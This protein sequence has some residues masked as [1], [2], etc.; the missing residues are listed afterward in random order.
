MNLP[1]YFEN[2]EQ[3]HVG[4][5]DNRSYYIPFASA[6]EALL[7]DRQMSDRFLSLNGLWGFKY[8]D[9]VYDL[10][11]DLQDYYVASDEIPVPSVWQNYG[12]DRHQYTNLKYPIPYDPPYVPSENPTGVYQRSFEL[13]PLGT[14][15]YYLNF[16]GVDSCFYVWVNGQFVGY[17]QV[18]HSTSEFEITKHLC[19]GDNDITVAVLKWCDGTYLEDQDKLRMSGIFR[20]V[21]L[22]I[23]P[24]K[25]IRDFFCHVDLNKAYADATLDVEL[26]YQKAGRTPKEVAVLAT[27]IDPEGEVVAQKPVEKGEVHFDVKKVEKW[28]AESPKLYSLLLECEEEVICQKIGFRKVEIKDGVLLINGQ[29]IK[30][31]GVN[32]HDSDPFTGYV[33]SEEQAMT[34]LV[35]MKEHNINAIRT[36]H[37]PNAPWFPELCNEFGFYMIAESDL[38]SHGSIELAGPESWIDKYCLPPHDPQFE[39]ATLDRQMLSVI[40]DKNQP[41][42]VIWSLGNEAGFGPNFEKAGRWVK[43]YDPSRPVH[44]ERAHDDPSYYQADFSMIDLYSRMYASCEE[45][46]RYFEEKPY[47]KPYI[48][49]EFIHAMGNGPG[50]A[51]EYWQAMERHKGSCGGFVWEWCDHSVYAG[52]T[53]DGRDKF[54]YGGDFG[55]FPSDGNFCMDGLVYPDRRVSESLLEYKNVIR[56]VRSALSGRDLKHLKVT[57]YFDFTDL[58]DAVTLYLEVFSDGQIEQSFILPEFSCKPHHSVTIDLPEIKVTGKVASLRV[59]YIQRRD[60]LLTEAGREMGFDEIILKEE[61]LALPAQ[62]K[63]AGGKAAGGDDINDAS[64]YKIR[65]DA[66]EIILTGPSFRYVFNKLQG[67]F[68]SLCHENVERLK[69][70]MAFSIRRA[71]TD[72]DQFLRHEWEAC[73]YDRALPKVYDAK[74][75]EKDGLLRLVVKMSLAPIFLQPAVRFTATYL[76]DADGSLDLK[77]QAER[78]EKMAELPRFGLSLLLPR[79]MERC[80]YFGYGPYESYVDKHRASYL[81]LFHTTAT[82]NYV[83]YL[84][85]Q[86]NGSH[87]HTRELS[88]Y[89]KEGTGVHVMSE[90][91]FSFDLLPYTT[92]EL[93]TKKHEFELEPAGMTVLSLD[94]KQNGIGSNSCGPRLLKE[95]RFDEL[96]FN[97]HVR[98]EMINGT[99]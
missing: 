28:N 17:S 77:V 20:D 67:A 7:G 94:Y 23:R 18:S 96:K 3:L 88:V 81:G 14:D 48:L 74:V 38:E 70:P 84:K 92:E 50:D 89:D 82:E 29:N 35:L 79:E 59:V 6:E 24:E 73:G 46:D 39:K 8:Y 12:Y 9:S 26:S 87:W 10:P 61:A 4:T 69:A 62:K 25:H 99:L 45:M 97:W 83:P 1:R 93:A 78:C 71:P 42:V 22:L 53:P 63:A 95:Y 47:D 19:E 51:E 43:A 5:E 40:R 54:L 33:I 52:T 30:F 72:N 76:I 44:Y 66:R 34:D 86:E 57:N 41:A 11:D 13:G 75:S 80:D 64:A 15:R 31:R 49:C 65:E 68:T 56:P 2:P 37:Y 85:P 90:T 32:R 16:E 36:S 58:K 27:L 55:E 91:P 98:L 60:D 21:Y